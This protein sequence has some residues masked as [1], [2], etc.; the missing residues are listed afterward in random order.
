MTKILYALIFALT[1]IS[2]SAQNYVSQRFIEGEQYS[3]VNNAISSTNE[4]REYF[5]F[6]CPHCYNYEPFFH[7]IKE[8]IPKGIVF[9]RNHVD[10]LRFTTKDMQ[11]NLSKAMVV[12]KIL[13]KEEDIVAAIFNY[14]HEQKSAFNNIGDIQSLFVARGV[15]ATDFNRLFKSKEVSDGALKM[16]ALQNYFTAKKG[17]TSVPTVII[18]GKYRI[19]HSSLNRDHFAEEY[20]ALVLYL[21]DLKQ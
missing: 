9:E 6:Y 12:A 7:D 21:L 19:N 10:F 2:A 17:I 13:G 14:L 1:T 4:I 11:Y 8:A 18:N 20:L 15:A 16:Q 3:I 5:S